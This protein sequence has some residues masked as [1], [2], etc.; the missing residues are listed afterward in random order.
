LSP[1]HNL[2]VSALNAPGNA[3]PGDQIIVNATIVNNGAQ[4][5]TNVLISFRVNDVELNQVLIPVFD[6][7]LFQQVSF[8]WTPPDIGLYTVTVNVSMPSVQE[9][10][11]E[12][13]EQYI[14]VTAGPDVAVTSITAPEFTGIGRLTLINGTVANLGITDEWID[15]IFSVNETIEGTQQVYLTNR[16]ATNVSFEW[17]PTIPGVCTLEL[18]AEL[19]GEEPY[20]GNN[21]LRRNITVFYTNGYV[22]LVDDDDVEDTYETYYETVL[23]AN[24]YLYD[25]WHHPSQGTPSTARMLSYDAVIWFTGDDFHETLNPQDQGNLGMYL[26]QSGRLFLSGQDIGWDLA[27]LGRGLYFY[28]HFLHAQYDVDNTSTRMV[29]GTGGDPIG[30]GLT[31]SIQ[32]GDGANNQLWPDG[33]QAI[34]PGTVVFTYQG[35]QYK[36][37][38]KTDTLGYKVV[39]FA[40]GFEAINTTSMRNEVMR[41]V[42]E[43]LIGRVVDPIQS[44]V[45]LAPGHL[46]TC[47]MGDGPTYHC[48]TV[49][50][51]NAAGTPI[52]WI[53]SSMFTFT[54]N[55]VGIGTHWYGT[56]S[57]HFSALDPV[58]DENG[59]IR[60]DICGDTSIYG[61]IT[62]QVT[63]QGIA[64]NDLDVLPCKT[65][66]YDTNGGIMLGDFVTFAGDYGRS[67]WRS[68]FSGDGIVGLS[69]FVMFAQHY[70][71]HA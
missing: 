67:G 58:T 1:D 37:A 38:V 55:P 47:P 12:D 11:Y 54:I 50:V 20:T 15:I 40:F 32:G 48:V 2:A 46:T 51:K 68:D 21:Y 22:L 45:T 60:F 59:Q 35:T 49:T 33:I 8:E 19:T 44:S 7:V 52:P 14:I 4:D 62:I 27:Y 71:H 57:C 61:N 65:G 10:S 39:Y 25:L 24:N 5:E 43:W 66:D 13:N 69:D 63:V 3:R 36:A 31:F 23:T 56:L 9:W 6:H 42:L 70:A 18:A 41:R 16:T 17:I 64:L 53:P 34:S 29:T 26:N 28:Q 30:N